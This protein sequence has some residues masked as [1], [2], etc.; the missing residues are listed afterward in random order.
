MASYFPISLGV[1]RQFPQ[2][3]G[4][5]KP[6]AE[7]YADPDAFR[8]RVFERDDYTCKCCGFRAED[9]QEILFKNGDRKN[10]RLENA[11]TTCIFCNQCFD[12]SKV[13]AMQSGVL[14][15]LPEISQPV[16]HH[17]MRAIYVARVSQGPA[18]KSAR[19]ALEVLM[20]RREQARLWIGTDNPKF[21]AAAMKDFLSPK[22]Y[23]QRD[24]LLKGIRLMPLDRRV[25]KNDDKG[26]FNQFP[27]ILASWRSGD[28]PFAKLPVADWAKYYMKF[29]ERVAA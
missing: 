21:L 25:I 26:E 16:L 8:V 12:L 27:L 23:E 17:I 1:V 2:D 29:S 13:G 7:T 18:A 24:A 22:K 11:I 5:R 28:G 3:A 19:H 14:I 4:K 20:S 6:Q 9:Y 10:M 15:W